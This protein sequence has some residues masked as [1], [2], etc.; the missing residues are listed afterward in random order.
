VPAGTTESRKRMAQ[1]RD[2]IRHEAE[3]AM[4]EWPPSHGP[5]RLWAEFALKPPAS[6]P[7]RLHGWKPHTSKPDID[8][9]LRALCDALTGIAW[10]DDSQVCVCAVNKGYAWDG[11]TGVVV[12]VEPITDDAARAFATASQHLR[13]FVTED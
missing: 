13:A 10:V 3:T 4:A 2:D 7:K 9:L 6:M 8:K 12:S 1:W 5:I 11:R